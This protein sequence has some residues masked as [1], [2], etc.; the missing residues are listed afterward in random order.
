MIRNFRV[1]KISN[2]SKKK[3]PTK[4]T[5]KTKNILTNDMPMVVNFSNSNFCLPT[6]ELW[7]HPLTSSLIRKYLFKIMQFVFWFKLSYPAHPREYKK[8]VK[9]RWK[10]N[11]WGIFFI[12][13]EIF[14]YFFQKA[15][16]NTYYTAFKL[17]P[18]QK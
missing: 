10:N 4:Q 11:F 8:W 13:I 12:W 9:G 7:T 6:A 5:N 2:H 1:F 15:R 14:S 17:T 18:F 3:K 16:D